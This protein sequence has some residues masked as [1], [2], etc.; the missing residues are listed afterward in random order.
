MN[1]PG[2]RGDLDRQIRTRTGDT[3]ISGTAERTALRRDLPVN[4][5]N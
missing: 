2:P 4:Q 5:H 1:G 3:T